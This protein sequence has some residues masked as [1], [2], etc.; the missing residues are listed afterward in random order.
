MG[1][2][3]CLFFTSYSGSGASGGVL[4]EFV[5]GGMEVELVGVWR[6][7]VRVRDAEDDA[8]LGGSAGTTSCV[9]A[10][11]ATASRPWIKTCIRLPSR[12]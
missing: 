11:R 12:M 2:L 9:A 1:C 10:T 7:R 5:V 6:V 8:G 3:H 4:A